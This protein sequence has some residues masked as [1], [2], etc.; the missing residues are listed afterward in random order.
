MSKIGE[1]SCDE[2]VVSTCEQNIYPHGHILGI[3][4]V[5][6]NPLLEPLNPLRGLENPDMSYPIHWRSL[7]IVHIEHQALT[8][9]GMGSGHYLLGCTNGVHIRVTYLST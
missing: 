8:K 1:S 7:H 2:P 3:C 9:R 5:I 4:S 6:F